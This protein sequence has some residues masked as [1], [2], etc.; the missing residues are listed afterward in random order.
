MKP[1]SQYRCTLSLLHVGCKF[2]VSR[3]S[4]LPQRL[5]ATSTLLR[6]LPSRGYHALAD[7]CMRDSRCVPGQ[8]VG[9]CREWGRSARGVVDKVRSNAKPE[10]VGEMMASTDLKKE[11]KGKKPNRSKTGVMSITEARYGDCDNVVKLGLSARGTR[12]FEQ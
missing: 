6:D 10:N 8:V 7:Y 3:C 5:L 2:V 12:M 1:Y 9:I 4:I 11:K